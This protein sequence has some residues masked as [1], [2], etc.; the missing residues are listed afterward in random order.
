MKLI[1]KI[2]FLLFVPAIIFS[3]NV[4]NSK[5]PGTAVLQPVALVD[6]ADHIDKFKNKQLSIIL[7][8]KQI[9]Y[10]FEKIVFYDKNNHDIIFDF[11]DKKLKKKIKDFNKSLHE[12]LKY[13]VSFK[14]LDVAGD[15]Y[16]LGELITFS[17]VFLDKIP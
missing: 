10:V 1:K 3:Q 15:E 11:S 5:S 6:I 7:R 17:P 4:T 16:I 9:D 8:L 12:G 2:L 14:V 13:K